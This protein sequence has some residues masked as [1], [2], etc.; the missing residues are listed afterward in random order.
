MKETTFAFM[1][2]FT[3]QDATTQLASLEEGLRAVAGVEQVCGSFDDL[4]YCHLE[5]T[6]RFADAEAAKDMHETIMNLLISTKD[7]VIRK[8]STNLTDVFG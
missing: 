7:L 6:A 4:S 3:G 1:V 8:V 2:K 5:V